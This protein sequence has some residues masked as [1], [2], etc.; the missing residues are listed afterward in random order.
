VTVVP[1]PPEFVDGA[2]S[3][4]VFN[5]LT[6]ALT[7]ALAPPIAALIQVNSQ[8]IANNTFT[9]LTFDSEGVDSAGGH[10]NSTNNSRYT[11]VYAGWYELSGGLTFTANASGRR[12]ARWTVN[13]TSVTGSLAGIPGNASI[14]GYG[15]RT[16]MAFLDVGDYAELQVYQDSGG[17]LSTF[18]ANFEYRPSAFIRWV[19]NA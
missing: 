18:V 5:R 7:F 8:A 16:V 17:S 6:D 19:S 14:I 2:P 9:A 11:A 3:S 12:L 13:G 15:P 10:D 1:S 4:S